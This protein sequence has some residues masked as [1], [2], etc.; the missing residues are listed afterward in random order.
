MTAFEQQVLTEL[1]QLKLATLSGK[2]T[3]TLTECAL[4]TGMSE[5]TIRNLTSAKKIP[6][7]KKGKLI[8]FDTHEIDTWLKERKVK[9]VGDL[10]MIATNYKGKKSA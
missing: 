9:T 4:Y 7:Y 8:F 10:E 1:S 5:G 2:G 6:H 3:L